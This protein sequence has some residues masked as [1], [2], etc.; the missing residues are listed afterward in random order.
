MPY[1]YQ[2]VRTLP[3]T[4]LPARVAA[5]PPSRRSSNNLCQSKQ[6]S[7]KEREGES[8][9]PQKRSGG[10]AVLLTLSIESPRFLVVKSFMF[11]LE[12]QAEAQ[13]LCDKFS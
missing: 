8:M 3:S 9:Y 7:R 12:Q 6:P 2:K 1:V 13:N 4:P 5:A 10:Y 11:R